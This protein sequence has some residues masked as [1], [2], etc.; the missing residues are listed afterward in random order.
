M[1]KEQAKVFH[2]DIGLD[3]QCDYSAGWLH[4]CKLHHGLTFHA[5]FEEKRSADREAAAAFIAQFVKLV[6]DGK[7]SPEQIYESRAIGKNNVFSIYFSLNCTSLIQPIRNS[8]SRSLKCRY[9]TTFAMCLLNAVNS[10]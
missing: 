2:K 8:I 6:S 10:G 3:Y 9:G 4:R 7:L 1:V 5:T